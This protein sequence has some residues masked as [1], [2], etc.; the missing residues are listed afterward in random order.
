L[1]AWSDGQRF[2]YVRELNRLLL[3]DERQIARNLAIQFIVFV[4]SLVRAS[5]TVRKP[6]QSLIGQRRMAMAENR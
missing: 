6:Q 2:Q 3:K 1:G 4:A 5:V